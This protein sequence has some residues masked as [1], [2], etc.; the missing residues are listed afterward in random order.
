MIRIRISDYYKDDL[1]KFM[2]EDM[3]DLLDEAYFN[4]KFT[5]KVPKYL[6]DQFETNKNGKS[7]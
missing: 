1:F 2:H 3:F 7:S 6:I 5:V 4:K